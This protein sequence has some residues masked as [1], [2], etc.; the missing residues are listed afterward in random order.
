MFLFGSHPHDYVGPEHRRSD[1][2]TVIPISFNHSHDQQRMGALDFETEYYGRPEVLPHSGVPWYPDQQQSHNDYETEV[3]TRFSDG[4]TM[5][6][7]MP[8]NHFSNRDHMPPVPPLTS[9]HHDG[10]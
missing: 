1:G 6:E 9:L 3:G 8:P 4:E 5:I 2:T 7:D 10:R